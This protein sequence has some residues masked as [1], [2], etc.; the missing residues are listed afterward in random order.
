MIFFKHIFIFS[1]FFSLILN[2]NATSYFISTSLG[3]D[4]NNGLSSNQPFKSIE[5][6]NSITFQAGDSILFKAGESWEGMFWLKGSGDSNN[7]IVVD[8]YGGVGKATINGNG[9]QSCI[10]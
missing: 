1:F 10:L 4:N 9:Y 2:A 7:S 8:I 6:L 5:K 3:N